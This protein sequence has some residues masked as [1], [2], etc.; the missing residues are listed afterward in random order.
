MEDDGVRAPDHVAD[1]RNMMSRAAAN[2]KGGR[3][4]VEYINPFIESVCS[5][6]STMLN[7]EAKRRD[8]GVT[9]NGRQPQEMTALVGLSG[10]ARGTVALSLPTNTA[11]AMVNRLL[12]T[13]T[14]LSDENV[15]DGVAELV[16]MIA[17]GAKVKLSGDGKPIDLSLPTVIRGDGYAVDYPSGVKWL[18]VPFTSD[19]GS[20]SL[21]VTFE[22]QKTLDEQKKGTTQ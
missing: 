18:D 7:S 15:S 16:N 17:G 9:G 10:A 8:V 6:F 22:K 12:G 19:L 14:R 2:E 4:Q 3:M 11:L 5:V 20:F 21:R 13:D 1:P